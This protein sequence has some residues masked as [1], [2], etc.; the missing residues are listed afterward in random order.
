MNSVFSKIFELIYR[1]QMTNDLYDYNIYGVC[2]IIMLVVSILFCFGFYFLFD[3]ARFSGFLPWFI[4]LVATT[5]TILFSSL[6]FSRSTLSKEGL[7][8]PFTEYLYFG[9]VVALYGIVI[10]FLLSLIVKRFRTNLVH[11][12]F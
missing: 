8:Y 2:G 10:F 5:V 3:H 1:S 4:A 12:P 6:F 11:S 9:F 7:D